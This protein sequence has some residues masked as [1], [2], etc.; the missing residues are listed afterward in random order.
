MGKSRQKKI[1]K[2]K[3]KTIG[4][5]VGLFLK[6]L[7]SV[8]VLGAC[9]IIAA[10][11]LQ[12]QS[13]L[14]GKSIVEEP[15]VPEQTKNIETIDFPGNVTEEKE[16]PVEEE[17]GQ[18]VIG[19]A[20]D[21]LL[22]DGYAIMSSYKRTGGKIEECIQGGLLDEMKQVD[23]MMI[24]NEFTY[25]SRGT[26]TPEK[27]FT[28][29][30]DPQ[31]VEILNDMGVDLVSLANNHAYD[32]G[33]VSLLDTL[34]TLENA[35]IQYVGAGRNIEEAVKPSIIEK[36]GLKIAIL[37]ATQIER[38]DRPDTK[39][40][41]ADAAGVFRC[42]QPDRLLQEIKN[43]KDSNDFV[44]VY[45]HWGTE[46]TV[47]LDWAQKDQ[48]KKYVEAGADLI[49]GDHPHC[50][51]QLEYVEGVPVIYSLGNFWFNS[52]PL[53][54]AMV[55]ATIGKEGLLE[56]EFLPCRQED[57]KVALLDG[58]EKERVFEYM[59]S[60]SP[61]VLIGFDGVITDRKSVV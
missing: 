36:N 21:V 32:Y 6:V 11:A 31:N 54:T 40:A 48:V 49:I 56:F 43:A 24:N 16:Q 41:T 3:R 58:G 7:I 22:D 52:K 45:V 1:H 28:F 59:R 47:E 50:L 25:T 30:A 35:G 5:F 12:N 60:I 2:N 18:V 33:E 61:G 20:G 13:V 8:L 39:E 29:R 14:T 4:H 37:S 44:V 53:D 57:S 38:L 10:Y 46:N 51:Q 55:R 19:F 9:F 42:W 27:A 15:V 26:P 23:V 17:A 34:D